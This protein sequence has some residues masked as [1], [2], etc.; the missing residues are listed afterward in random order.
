MRIGRISR[1]QRV[2]GVV[3]E[4][5]VVLDTRRHVDSVSKVPL[6]VCVL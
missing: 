4:P 2:V 3:A 6:N 5:D 1:L